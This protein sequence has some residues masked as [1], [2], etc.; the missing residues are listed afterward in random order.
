MLIPTEPNPVPIAHLLLSN[1]APLP[2]LATKTPV[3][4][5]ACSK[6]M[7]SLPGL[8]PRGRRAA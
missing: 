3:T 1:N 8:P 7:G 2:G 6:P 5:G 4:Q